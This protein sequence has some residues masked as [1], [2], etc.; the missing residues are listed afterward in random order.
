MG[1]TDKFEL[2]N[3]VQIPKI[4]FGVW[5]TIAQRIMRDAAVDFKISD[6]DMQLLV[7]IKIG[8]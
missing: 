6:E 4:G 3:G 1:M 5:P 8:R 2:S 7:A